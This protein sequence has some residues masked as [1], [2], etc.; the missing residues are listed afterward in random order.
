MEHVFTCDCF[1]DCLIMMRNE[2]KLFKI[3]EKIL[4]IRER[5]NIGFITI[6]CFESNFFCFCFECL[7]IF[8]S[9]GILNDYKC[10][11]FSRKNL[12]N[13]K[14]E[15]FLVFD[16]LKKYLIKFKK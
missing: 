12:I 6:F 1:V 9:S 10:F 3:I 14:S 5:F 8:V 11:D 13:C 15:N 2:S 16:N 4:S 7:K